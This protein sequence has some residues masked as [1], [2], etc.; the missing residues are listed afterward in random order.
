MYRE[1]VY[2]DHVECCCVVYRDHNPSPPAQ[3][4][5]NY[6]DCVKHCRVVC[7]NREQE[8]GASLCIIFKVSA[9]LGL[10]MILEGKRS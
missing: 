6:C 10:E 2:S 8:Q 3:H 9:V 7:C 5:L 1:T 4:V